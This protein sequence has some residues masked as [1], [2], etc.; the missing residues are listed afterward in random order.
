M[1]SKAP[2][3]K[4]EG[5]GSKRQLARCLSLCSLA[6]FLLRKPTSGPHLIWKAGF[7]P[8][9]SWWLQGFL[10][11][12]CFAFPFNSIKI[13]LELPLSQF[14]NFFINETRNPK[15]D[16][17]SPGNNNKSNTQDFSMLCVSTLSSFA[18]GRQ[19]YVWN[20]GKCW[21]HLILWLQI[22]FKH[23]QLLNFKYTCSLEFYPTCKS[24]TQLTAQHLQ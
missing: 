12:Q 9:C 10:A 4:Q 13:L 5:A 7:F 16:P 14:L 24:Y 15:G 1:W 18:D 2:N 20:W 19:W 11:N 23:T 22:L 8:V 17:I 6:H 3:Y 21:F